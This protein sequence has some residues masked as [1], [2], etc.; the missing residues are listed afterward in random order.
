LKAVFFD[1]DGVINN[2][3][4]YYV[5]KKEDFVLNNGLIEA[6]KY[7]K[8][9]GYKF[10]VVTNQSGIA[11]G[12]YTIEDVEAIHKLIDNALQLHDLKIEEYFYC[13]HHPNYGNCLCRKPNSLLFEKAIAKYKIETENSFMVGDAPRDVEAAEKAGIKGILV[14]SNT[15][16]FENIKN[17]I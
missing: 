1:R 8:S 16:L 13:V 2:N 3:S 4:T 12:L 11:K 14:P 15:N 17:V 10:F 9:K 6:L 7:L 5:Y